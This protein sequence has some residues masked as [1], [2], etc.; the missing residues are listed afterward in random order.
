MVRPDIS[1]VWNCGAVWPS[2]KA[3][4]GPEARDCVAGNAKA[5]IQN[6]NE[7]R[8]EIRSRIGKRYWMGLM[9]QVLAANDDHAR[10]CASRQPNH[11]IRRPDCTIENA[12]RRLGTWPG[13]AGP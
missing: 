2:T 8:P 6:A 11:T 9:I 12:R 7:R 3:D 10:K 13:S 4:L 1:L 5:S